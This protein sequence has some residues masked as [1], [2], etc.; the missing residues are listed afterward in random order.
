MGMLIQFP[1]VSVA[2]R[3]AP[4]QGVA[5]EHPASAEIIILPVIRVEYHPTNNDGGPAEGSPSGKRR[6]RRA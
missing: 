1:E 5:G 2:P 6:R 4:M 3:V